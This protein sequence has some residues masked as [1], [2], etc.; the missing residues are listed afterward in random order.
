MSQT[1]VRSARTA[2]AVEASLR[3]LGYSPGFPPHVAPIAR[4]VDQG[5][6][7]RRVCPACRRRGLGC[8]PYQK[9]MSYRCVVV[10]QCGYGEEA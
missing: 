8:K 3:E 4:A 6:A 7:R 10:C 9:G 5:S 1:A 2:A